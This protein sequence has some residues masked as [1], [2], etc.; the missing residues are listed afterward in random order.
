MTDKTLIE[1]RVENNENAG[2]Y[3]TDVLLTA[4]LLYAILEDVDWVNN[5]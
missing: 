3:E 1:E 2:F 5:D 4:S